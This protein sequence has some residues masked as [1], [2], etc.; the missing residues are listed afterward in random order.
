MRKYIFISLLLVMCIVNSCIT[1]RCPGYD[2][3]DYRYISFRLGDTL[4]YVSNKSDTI[5][6][7]V[8]DFF[9]KGYYEFK[10]PPDYECD[11]DTYYQTDTKQ[12]ISIKEHIMYITGARF[13]NDKAYLR[14]DEPKDDCEKEESDTVINGLSYRKYVVID[15]SGERR[16]DRYIKLDYRGIIEFHDKSTG[17]TWKQIW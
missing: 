4:T 5:H 2:L 14:D 17:L 12:G 10:A 15:I 8:I 1:A 16:I 7:V 13:C 11:L 9:S 3:N 6:L